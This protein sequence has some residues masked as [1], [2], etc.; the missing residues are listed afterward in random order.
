MPHIS[1]LSC[2]L[3]R[4]IGSSPNTGKKGRRDKKKKKNWEGNGMVHVGPVRLWKHGHPSEHPFQQV[5]ENRENLSILLIVMMRC[6]LSW[7]RSMLGNSYFVNARRSNTKFS[8]SDKDV[9]APVISTIPDNWDDP[10][11][12]LYR[13][14]NGEELLDLYFDWYLEY[15]GVMQRCWGRVVMVNSED[16]LFRSEGLKTRFQLIGCRLKEDAEELN[17]HAKKQR[18]SVE[19]MRLT[20]KKDLSDLHRQR[21]LAPLLPKLREHERLLR[22]MGY[23]DRLEEAECIVGGAV[24]R[25]FV[26]LTTFQVRELYSVADIS[27]LPGL[28]MDVIYDVWLPCM[29]TQVR[30]QVL[31]SSSASIEC[32]V[33]CIP[34][35]GM[36]GRK[37]LGALDA[38]QGSNKC[39]ETLYHEACR[40]PRVVVVAT[41]PQ[42]AIGRSGPAVQD[43]VVDFSGVYN[44]STWQT[45]ANNHYT[46]LCHIDSSMSS[47]CHCLMKAVQS[48]MG[49][50]NVALLYGIGVSAGSQSLLA[51]LKTGVMKID[52]IFVY[53][54][55]YCE[56]GA[57]CTHSSC[58]LAEGVCTALSDGGRVVVMHG[59]NDKTCPLDSAHEFVKLLRKK[60]HTSRIHFEE[61][62]GR[63]HDLEAE[64][65]AAAWS[66]MCESHDSNSS[67][68]SSSSSAGSA[69]GSVQSRQGGAPLP[70]PPAPRPQSLPPGP[71]P[72]RPRSPFAMSQSSVPNPDETP[73]ERLSPMGKI[74]RV[75][76]R[77]RAFEQDQT[78]VL[79]QQ[80]RESKEAQQR[81]QERLDAQKRLY[82]DWMQEAQRLHDEKVQQLRQEQAEQAEQAAAQTQELLA[83]QAEQAA[84]PMEVDVPTEET[85]NVTQA[86]QTDVGGGIQLDADMLAKVIAPIIV[87]FT[88]ANA[89]I[90]GANATPA[91]VETQRSRAIFRNKK[92]GKL[93][94]RLK[95]LYS[96]SA[97]S[98]SSSPAEWAT[99]LE[100][101]MRC[102]LEGV[103]DW[104]WRRLDGT[105]H[106]ILSRTQA[107]VVLHN[108][109]AADVQMQAQINQVL[110]A[111]RVEIAQRQ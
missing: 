46:A 61:K 101:G 58:V 103:A 30:L 90:T 94:K 96:G 53:G 36:Q 31:I 42:S 76:D 24:P 25:A 56:C 4:S 28:E 65:L 82:N 67:R 78:T 20:Y 18:T 110:A 21:R 37:K 51:V 26:P 50:T 54:S 39:W 97:V 1:N 74:I 15:L 10:T 108:A 12:N 2:G 19:E 27:S 35:A 33:L 69:F 3:G 80:L 8:D 86:S 47:Q 41:L 102:F 52:A 45:K 111:V 79:Q 62:A 22:S 16:F 17:S 88:F 23:I 81:L 38:M 106:D 107:T 71:L 40:I 9:N 73:D 91:M 60:I 6:P 105:L 85:Q 84:A 104:G 99:L 29:A 109:L 95:N 13:E 5:M 63:G 48:I 66:K 32:L 44:H 34:G 70:P 92:I 77:K 64:V 55:Y 75:N 87:E 72:P 11:K 98:S 68:L 43:W 59:S 14:R 100:Q 89:G 49:K 57:D 83:Q 7:V 93:N